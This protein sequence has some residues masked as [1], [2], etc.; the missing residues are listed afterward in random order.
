METTSRSRSN[1]ETSPRSRLAYALIAARRGWRVFPLHSCEH[2]RC[3]CGDTEC[4]HPGKHP[5]TTHGVKDATTDP[6]QMRTWWRE[7]P[8]ANIGIATG[9][10]RGLFVLDVDKRHGGWNSWHVLAKRLGGMPIEGV[11]RT[12]DGWHIYFSTREDFRNHVGIERGIDGRGEGGYVV[13]PG[14]EHASGHIYDW[15]NGITPEMI[16]IAPMPDCLAEQLRR[17]VARTQTSL[18]SEIPRTAKRDVG[19]TGWRDATTG[20]RRGSDSRGP[21]E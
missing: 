20:R 11:V 10:A 9:T 17:P 8:N 4:E 16:P 21:S 12:G 2:G 3:S 14:S 6:A 1:P 15:L 18:T 19:Q 13:G 7:Y 5:R